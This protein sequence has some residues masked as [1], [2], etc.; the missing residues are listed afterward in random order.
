MA[1]PDELKVLKDEGAATYL[2]FKSKVEGTVA[3]LQKDMDA[4]M[5][6]GSTSTVAADGK[7][8]EIKVK[9]DED[10]KALVWN[11]LCLEWLMARLDNELQYLFLKRF[12]NRHLNRTIAK[13]NV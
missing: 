1:I 10:L 5:R 6:S 2:L 13:Q 11:V 12:V 8:S 9:W 7:P 3:S 4:E